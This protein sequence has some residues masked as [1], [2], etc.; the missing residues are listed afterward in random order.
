MTPGF[1]LVI[2]QPDRNRASQMDEPVPNYPPG[3]AGVRSRSRTNSSGADGSRLFLY[4][5]AFRRCA[6]C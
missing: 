1:D 5:V 3:T 6:P 4:A 2:G